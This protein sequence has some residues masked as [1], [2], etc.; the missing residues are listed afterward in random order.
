MHTLQLETGFVF[1]YSSDSSHHMTQD[2]S[3]PV[4]Y[5]VILE[6]GNK[7]KY[8]LSQ[9]CRTHWKLLPGGAGGGNG[10]VKSCQTHKRNVNL[11]CIEMTMCKKCWKFFF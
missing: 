2:S 5:G 8:Y 10:N 9:G 4:S 7:K 11:G 6:K 3:F 1:N